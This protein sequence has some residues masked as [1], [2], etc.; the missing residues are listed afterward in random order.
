MSDVD[1][2]QYIKSEEWKKIVDQRLKID[3]YTC[4]MCGCHGTP[5]NPLECH[6]LTYHNLGHEDPYKDVCM[7]CDACHGLV[8]RMMN[9]ITS[10]DG[11]RGWNNKAVPRITVWTYNGMLQQHRKENLGNAK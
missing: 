9:R 2:S 1:Y 3:N 11:R 6:H 4:V 5:G 7:L 8:T 10:A